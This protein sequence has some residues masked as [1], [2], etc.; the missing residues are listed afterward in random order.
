MTLVFVLALV[1]VLAYVPHVLY[2]Q[3]VYEDAAWR[4]L[5]S[6]SMSTWW[7]PRGGTRLL[8]WVQGQLTREPWLVHG[9]SLAMHVVVAW[10][11]VL[12]MRRLGLSRSAQAVAAVIV[13]LHPLSVETVAY[14]AQQSEL[15]AA[16][17]VLTAC[18]LATYRWWR[19]SVAVGIVAALWLGVLG[20]ESALVGLGLVP[21]I[22]ALRPWRPAWAQLW[23]PALVATCAL[24]AGLLY[25]GGWSPVV[26]IGE[27]PGATVLWGEWVRLQSTAA[28]R[29]LWL[30]VVPV[31]P[32]TVD[33]DYHRVSMTMQIGSVVL[34]LLLAGSALR[35]WM[36]SRSYVTAGILWLLIILVPRFIVHTPRSVMN[37][38]QVYLWL[39]GFALVVGAI[40]D[41]C[42]PSRAKQEA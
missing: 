40:M 11:T 25:Y 42:P 6:A 13:T 15:V 19:P 31:G 8:W 35:G 14:A 2:G 7:R 12:L 16:I 9:V 22:M 5:L 23:I 18:V 10:L 21:L 27:A 38:H 3:W 32:F 28:V 20:K 39:P 33:Y 26:N 17:G 24:L 41:N 34:L 30:L 4:P 36:E 1:L 29:L 37:E